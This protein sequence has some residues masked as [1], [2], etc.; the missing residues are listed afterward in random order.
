MAFTECD[1]VDVGK[2]CKSCAADSSVRTSVTVLSKVKS[3]PSSS[4]CF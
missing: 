3:S 2:S 1:S 4:K